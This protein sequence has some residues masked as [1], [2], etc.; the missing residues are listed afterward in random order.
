[1]H[2]FWFLQQNFILGIN[3]TQISCLITSKACFCC[4]KSIES[5]QYMLLQSRRN[6]V[7]ISLQRRETVSLQSFS[8]PKQGLHF[9]FFPYSC[10]LQPVYEKKITVASG[11]II[12]FLLARIPDVL[13]KTN[14][15]KEESFFIL[16][17]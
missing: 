14:V 10:T 15:V 16:A 2:M 17:K 6:L 12:C 7:R 11:E 13:L 3:I 8:L 1:M 9:F 4:Y 5:F